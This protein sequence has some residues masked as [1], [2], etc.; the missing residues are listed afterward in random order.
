MQACAQQTWAHRDQK[1]DAEQALL[2]S[3][4]RWLYA[5][6]ML[7][8]C[9]YRSAPYVTIVTEPARRVLRTQA[10]QTCASSAQTQHASRVLV[11]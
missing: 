5:Q 11:A 3:R 9:I 2:L 8:E 10:Q 7:Q 6:L 4:K 1:G